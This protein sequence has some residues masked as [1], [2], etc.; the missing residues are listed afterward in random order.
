M[1]KDMMLYNVIN[2]IRKN[3]PDITDDEITDFL[4]T[5]ISK[6]KENNNE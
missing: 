6:L 1:N 5:I 2:L 4:Q 3:K